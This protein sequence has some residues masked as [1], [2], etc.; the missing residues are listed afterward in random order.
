MYC[1]KCGVELER[2]RKECPLCKTKV[3]YEE[4]TQEPEEEYP[5]VKI[6]L[7][8]MNKKKIK[9]RLYFIML[10]LSVI[11]ILE[12]LLGNIAINGRLTWGYFVIPSLIL[13][14]IAVFIA[15]DGW[16]LK[17]NLLLLS[18]SLTVFLLI[19]DLYDEKLTWSVKIGIPIVISFFILG[20]IFSKIKKHKKS[21]I[22]VF[23]YFL[24]LIGIFIIS[25]EIIISGKISWSLLASIPL[26]VFGLMFKHFYEEYDEELE[27][28]MHL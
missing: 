9:S 5:E 24:I 8:K 23:N 4:L 7:Y 15:T 17:K 28:R 10:T 16:N 11:S 3:M 22:K 18:T 19:L 26:I 13:T 12:V 2:G 14:N 21:K 6:N 1:V 20:L 27:K 25:I